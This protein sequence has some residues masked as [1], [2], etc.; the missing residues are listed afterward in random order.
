[1][2]E[3]QS[4]IRQSLKQGAGHGDFPG[5]MEQDP[6]IN[7]EALL[8]HSQWIRGLARRLVVES[9]TDDLVQE[10]W[11]AALAH[12][13]RRRGK[14]VRAWLGSVVRN[15]ASDRHRSTRHRRDR[16]TLAASDRAGDVTLPTPEELVSRSEEQR[17]VVDAV[18]ALAEPYRS[19]LLLRYFEGLGTREIAAREH[20]PEATV[21]TRLHRG[22]NQ[23]REALD[24]R[25]GGNRAAWT[26]ALLPL[27]LRAKPLPVPVTST[28]ASSPSALLPIF[29]SL[30]AMSTAAKILVSS[31]LLL[32]C[33]IWWTKS[34]STEALNSLDGPVLSEF[35]SLNSLLDRP[36]DHEAMREA[37]FEPTAAEPSQGDS[38][39]V[40]NQVATGVLQ[41][42]D[43]ARGEP[44]W[45]Y[46]FEAQDAL[47]VDEGR[48]GYAPAVGVLETDA[49]GRAAV[50]RS[51]QAIRPRH[52][53]DSA[54][55]GNEH[56][57]L[58]RGRAH[59]EVIEVAW[60]NGVG[61]AI[62][63][64]PTTM[65]LKLDAPAEALGQRLFA[66][67]DSQES[68][69]I[70]FGPISSVREWNGR[71]FAR[72][73]VSERRWPYTKWLQVLSE[74]GHFIG[75]ATTEGL[76]GKEAETRIRLQARGAIVVAP[77]WDRSHKAPQWSIALYAG[78]V[79]TESRL[80]GE[81]GRPTQTVVVTGFL[82]TPLRFLVPG[83]YTVF[84][85]SNDYDDIRMVVEVAALADVEVAPVAV[86]KTEARTTLEGTVTS[87]TGTFDEPLHITAYDLEVSAVGSGQQVRVEW[88]NEGEAKVGRFRIENVFL[89]RHRLVFQGAHAD[90]RYRD[91][92]W[93]LPGSA[94]EAAAGEHVVVHLDDTAASSIYRF[95][96]TDAETS[97]P[98]PSL[99][100][101]WYPSV[102]S[103]V[104]GAVSALS[105][106]GVADLRGITELSAG[107][108]W[109]LADG[110]RFA[111]LGP[112][113]LT[114]ESDFKVPMKPGWPCIVS[115][116]VAE[117]EESRKHRMVS[118]IGIWCDGDYVGTSDN[119]GPLMFSLDGPPARITLNAEDLANWRVVEWFGV[120]ESGDLEESTQ[121]SSLVGFTLEH[122]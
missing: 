54:T 15:L 92:N 68:C 66:H 112:D 62:V 120:T 55:E 52:V 94:V 29:S 73:E 114:D 97:R 86:R 81:A 75:A 119:R 12:P 84:V 23:V 77:R 5:D 64:R 67:L 101:F 44:V 7:A 61:T 30:L 71:R 78:N 14:K 47:E 74:D 113:A 35:T 104:S 38:G 25:H 111:R 2:R 69:T 65:L 122:R 79:S 85:L 28:A 102:G 37:V 10:T 109:I 27:A 83:V 118:G 72:F 18:L 63:A 20:Q 96:A 117:G 36:A 8:E 3:P 76:Y 50:P 121:R 95:E 93:M 48:R 88:T 1:M 4:E 16:E 87:V 99:Q 89:H 90:G 59:P 91:V 13:E 98:L 58:Q 40:T 32:A 17:A 9:D 80:A 57:R 24:A 42:V 19:T 116:T 21:R 100:V 11:M 33:A 108:V 39:A 56:L 43:E 53:Y 34:P 46:R 22:L 82:V 110:Y 115:V 31:A 26:V 70:P 107:E 41:V 49:R 45:G 106:A 60:K 105:N 51:T 6:T 103:A